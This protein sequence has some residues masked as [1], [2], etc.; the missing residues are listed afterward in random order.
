MDA[1]LMKV[2]E[3]ML[4]ERLVA[5]ID[6][7]LWPRTAEQATRL[8]R[9]CNIRI[10]RIN[11][12]APKENQLHLAVPPFHTVAQYVRGDE[13]G[14]WSRFAA[15]DQISPELAGDIGDFGFG[16]DDV[17]VLDHR[18]GGSN[19]PVLRLEWVWQYPGVWVRCADTFDEFADMLALDKT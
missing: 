2:G 12:F 5:L 3:L 1:E 4:P 10:D 6:A 11:L 18:Q 19:P 9:N 15:L 16:S 7:G 13:S 17:I 8:Y 14:L